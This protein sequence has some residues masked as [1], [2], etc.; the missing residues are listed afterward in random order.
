MKSRRG[1]QK[2]GARHFR[3]IIDNQYEIRHV[4]EV[5]V[6]VYGSRR[7]KRKRFKSRQ[8]FFRITA[9]AAAAI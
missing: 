4:E 5:A 1:Y 8:T 2:K 6:V 7:E 9:A 3:R